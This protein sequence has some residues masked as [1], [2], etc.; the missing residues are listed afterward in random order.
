MPPTPQQ[1]SHSSTDERQWQAEMEVQGSSRFARE[2][3][4]IA[5]MEQYLNESEEV[6][7]LLGPEDSKVNLRASARKKRVST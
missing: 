5:K 7:L 4:V 6:E 2:R 3:T 1:S